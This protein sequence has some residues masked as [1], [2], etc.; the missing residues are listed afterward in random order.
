MAYDHDNLAGNGKVN[1]FYTMLDNERLQEFNLNTATFDD[2][3][4]LLPKLKGSVIQNA[5]I[6]YHN[7]CLDR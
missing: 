4:M 5:N 2:Y 7:W 1:Q 3:L 6:Y